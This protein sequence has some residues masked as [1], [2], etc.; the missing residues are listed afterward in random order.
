MEEEQARGMDPMAV[1]EAISKA[2]TWTWQQSGRRLAR[3]GV[4]PT[5]VEVVEEQA[6]GWQ[7]NDTASVRI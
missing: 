5:T 6:R 2:P 7:R 3:F 4:E 1:R